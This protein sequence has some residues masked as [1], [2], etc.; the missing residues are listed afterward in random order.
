MYKILHLETSKLYQKLVSEICSEIDAK[1]M[2]AESVEEAH[3][4]IKK[5]DVS[6]II[7]AME[8]EGGSSQEFIKSLNETEYHRIPII[9]FTGNDS[10]ESR[11]TMYELGIVDYI[12]KSQGRD[13]VKRDILAIRKEDPVSTQMQKLSYAVLDD[14]KMD[15]NIIER[16][17]LMSQI[18]DVTFFD[19]EK[20]FLAS[21]KPYDVYLIDFVLKETSGDKVIVNIK[22]KRPECV[23]IAIS[24]IDNVKTISRILSLGA[25]DFISKPFNYELFIA[26]LKTNIRSYL[27]LKEVRAKTEKLEEMAITDGLTGL[28]NRR[29][30]F[31]RLNQEVEKTARY[32]SIF[33]II[34]FDLDH[35]KSFNDN[36]GHQF[37]DDII[38]KSCDIIR[39]VL[40]SMDI[41]GRYGG[42]EFLI[43]LPEI[44]REGSLI[45][46]ERIRK[47]IE[48]ID[49]GIADVRVTISGGT[50]EY[51]DESVNDLVKR[52]DVLLYTA[53]E[54]G[55]NR[56]EG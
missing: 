23:I 37:G 51:R 24:G 28:Y 49:T 31:D 21:D 32:G 33:S 15:R 48:M 1:Y 39:S 35:F 36:Y 45:A 29:H 55:R 25:D 26:R 20:D 56:I 5:K 42:E 10:I 38:I 19:N 11:R 18:S 30:I 12:P 6:L 53:K 22:Q 47:K 27:L 44:N 41:A 13:A 50:A 9:V 34:M 17:F 43:I 4:L 8:I 2:S 46:A 7:T 52:A 16:I 3:A 14:S 40:R 54:K